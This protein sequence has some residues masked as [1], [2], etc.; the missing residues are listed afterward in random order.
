MEFIRRRRCQRTP[1]PSCSCCT[2][3]FGQGT[4]QGPSR[5]QPQRDSPAEEE[6]D[7]ILTTF[8]QPPP[9]VMS[10]ERE[11][12]V[13]H[14]EGFISNNL[15]LNRNLSSGPWG[16]IPFYKVY[17]TPGSGTIA[18][19]DSSAPSSGFSG[20]PSI[21]NLTVDEAAEGIENKGLS[22]FE[23]CGRHSGHCSVY[24][25]C[26]QRGKEKRGC[27]GFMGRV[28]IHLFAWCPSDSPYRMDSIGNPGSP[29]GSNPTP[30]AE[31]LV[32]APEAQHEFRKA[33]SIPSW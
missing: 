32:Q 16:D 23:A 3:E 2:W 6:D 15:Q 21:E 1:N 13:R 27:D 14:H 17:S 8:V 9:M 18:F 19:T 28:G 22:F 24:G 30:Q 26:C 10:P 33:K 29:S 7:N 11:A 25:F 12:F 5:S 20:S 4:R 31:A